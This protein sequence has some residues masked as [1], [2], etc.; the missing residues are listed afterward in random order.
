MIDTIYKNR[1]DFILIGLTGRIGSGCTTTAKFLSSD[2]EE[3]KLKDLC[4]DDN[5]NDTHRKKFIIHKYYKENWK[6]FQIVRA[7][8]VI[9]LFMLKYNFDEL[10]EILEK[11]RNIDKS[12]FSNCFASD[13]RAEL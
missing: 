6:K 8:D 12:K 11:L 9:V 13:W 10:N 7:S 1:K 5:S 4:I 3:H 2:I